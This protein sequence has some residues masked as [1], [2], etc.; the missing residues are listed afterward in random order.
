MASVTQIRQGESLPFSFNLG[1]ASLAGRTCTIYVKQH[2]KDISTI[3]REIPLDSGGNAFSGFLTSTETAPLKVGSW[4]IFGDMP[5]IIQ[6]R[7]RQVVTKEIR[8]DVAQTFVPSGIIV[9]TFFRITTSGNRR[10]TTAGNNR[11]TTK[12]TV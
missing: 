11:I 10:I 12:T 5:N 8:F 1:G 7:D 4:R 2:A 9:E 3:K 6:G